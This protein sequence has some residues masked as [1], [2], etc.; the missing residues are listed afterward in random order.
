MAQG[1][2]RGPARPLS[3]SV[4]PASDNGDDKA[5]AL[6]VIKMR[7]QATMLIPGMT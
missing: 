7:S 5:A 4:D 6:Q 2:L 1:E 3:L